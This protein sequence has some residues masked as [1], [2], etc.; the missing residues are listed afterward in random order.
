M[1]R[2]PKRSALTGLI[3]AL[4]AYASWGLLPLYWKPF[5]SASPLEIVSHRVIWSLI[6]LAILT[7]MYRQ[8]D[9]MRAVLRNGRRLA[10]LVSTASLLSVNWGLFIYGV[11]S[12]QV[13][14]T[15]LGYFLNP[16]VSILLAFLF[17]KERLGRVQMVAVVLAACGVL[18][19]GWHLGQLPLDRPRTRLL[20]RPVWASKKD[21]RRNA[22]RRPSG[23]D[24]GHGSGGPCFDLEPLQ[25]GPGRNL[26]VR[27]VSRSFS[28]ARE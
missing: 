16:L 25:S 24:S 11:V 9:E 22:A 4:L 20:L 26:E 19:F 5:G 21:R 2:S 6:L 27:L 3:Y 1:P 15:S 17:L 23:R 13:V 28:W 12:G 8:V 18:H 7:V 10:V 14:Q